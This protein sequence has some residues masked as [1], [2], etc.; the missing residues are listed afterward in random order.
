M[1]ILRWCSSRKELKFVCRAWIDFLAS[2]KSEPS[3]CEE[4]LEDATRSPDSSN[5]SRI[6]VIAR[7]E[8]CSLSKFPPGKTWSMVNLQWVKQRVITHVCPCEWS[9]IRMPV[10]KQNLITAVHYN[11]WS[12]RSG[13]Q[14]HTCGLRR[15]CVQRP[16]AG[17]FKWAEDCPRGPFGKGWW[18][19]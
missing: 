6:A 13:K 18:W 16:S 10:N 1:S 17:V 8:S 14:C 9:W 11:Q 5:V 12:G 2:S 19:P 3:S 4:S 7:L 15:Y